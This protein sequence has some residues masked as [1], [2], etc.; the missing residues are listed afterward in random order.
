M[1]KMRKRKQTVDFQEKS[2]GKRGFETT[3]TA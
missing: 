2:P 3:S 1:Q